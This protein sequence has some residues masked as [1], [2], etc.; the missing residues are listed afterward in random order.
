ML[1][2]N[3]YIFYIIFLLLFIS[4]KISAG[5]STK[6]KTINNPGKT[7]SAHEFLLNLKNKK[8]S[9]EVVNFE[10]IKTDFLTI[11]KQFSKKFKQSISVSPDIKRTIITSLIYN[12]PMDQAFVV[13]MEQNE[14]EAIVKNDIVFIKK[15]YK[16]NLVVYIGAFIVFMIMV[17]L[18][19][20]YIKKIS[21]NKQKT[22]Y[23]NNTVN[24]IYSEEVLSKLINLFEVKKIYRREN[25]TLK[26]LSEELSIQPYVLSRIINEK[27]NKTFSQ[28]LNHYRVKEAKQ[29]LLEPDK[30]K[31]KKILDIAYS[32]GFGN[33]ATFNKIF[34]QYTKLTPSQFKEKGK[35]KI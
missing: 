16:I 22:I 24:P 23:Q 34:K 20:I 26:A 27:M 2:K 19:Y 31:Q 12:I 8:Y 17:F 7:I 9:G 4:I 14:L 29:L 3:K 21:G 10:F 11:I 25:F 6:D 32:V 15:I 33:K 5:I 28:L 13:F 1:K 30:E 35:G 18:G